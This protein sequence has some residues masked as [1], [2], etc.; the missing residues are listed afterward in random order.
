MW[1]NGLAIA[2]MLLMHWVH[3]EKEEG[4]FFKDLNS[5]S[6][7]FCEEQL[8][9]IRP[10]SEE[11]ITL[12]WKCQYDCSMNPV[13]SSWANGFSVSILLN[14]DVQSCHG[15]RAG[16]LPAHLRK[17]GSRELGQRK[18]IASKNLGDQKSIWPPQSSLSANSLS[19]YVTKKIWELP[20]GQTIMCIHLY[21]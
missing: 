16:T 8:K 14:A 5:E 21:A 4:C 10:L 3:L 12:C 20:H 11:K 1:L 9:K 17:S 18:G 7:Y 13:D 2:R 15:N 6:D 19:S